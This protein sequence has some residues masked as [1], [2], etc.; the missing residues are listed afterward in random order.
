MDL[1]QFAD[2]FQPSTCIL[3][4][5][6]RPDGSCGA[7]RIMAGNHAYYE[8][9]RLQGTEG[10]PKLL[11]KEFIP[12]SRYEEMVPKDLNFEH[13]CYSCA[14]L[15]KPM[16][17][18]INPAFF[19]CWFKITMLPLESTDPG[20][21]YCTYTIETYTSPDQ[22][23][24]CDLS[25]ESANDV[26]RT[27][28]KLRGTRDFRG[29]MDEVIED[30]R[31]ICEA[32]RCCIMLMD[33][34]TRTASMLCE[35]SRKNSSHSPIRLQ[36]TENLYSLMCSW[37]ETLAGSTCLII[38]N[39]NDMEVLRERNPKWYDSLTGFGVQSLVLFPLRSDGVTIGYIW[40]LDFDTPNTFRIKETLE[41]TAFFL[42]S[43]IANYQLVERLRIMCSLDLLT[44]VYNRNEMNSRI[45]AISRIGEL[46]A[47]I[48]VVFADL[49]GLKR[50]ND[51][52]GHFAG[53]QV[54]RQAASVLQEIF[55]HDQIF[56]AG[57]DEF[58]ILCENR[59]QE[60]LDACVERIRSYNQLPGCCSFA[61]G[62]S[63]AASGE[64]IRSAIHI[65]DVLMYQDKERHYTENP[66][67][68]YR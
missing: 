48:G 62:C 21:G 10:Y 65:A 49:N 27:C 53:D 50:V 36:E 25:Y 44:N 67:E 38:K 64:D 3:S 29:T 55:P 22:A 7:I 34:E 18:C 52:D 9:Y 2:R 56:R 60:D 14:I 12:G 35:A 41:L 42:A 47:P 20:I 23:L 43:E 61:A 4:V 1:Q 63:F 11:S 58:M 32:E 57:G 15:G 51:T 8:S 16:H 30:I 19:G 17:T 45:D 68:R 54:L 33:H 5:A 31:H 66:D 24:I 40:A 39:W 28:I 59:S 46:K 26:L 13:F 6:Q 37:E